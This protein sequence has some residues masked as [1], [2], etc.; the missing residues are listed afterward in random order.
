MEQIRAFIAVELPETVKEG[1]KRIQD[2]LRSTNPY[3]ARWVEPRGIHLTLKFLGN[4]D[5]NKIEAI[6]SSIKVVAQSVAPF[7]LEINGLGAF[8]NMRRVQVVWIGIKG[9]LERLQALQSSIES[10]LI[11]LGFAAENRT[12]QPHLTLARL[13]DT[14]TF[15]ER[16][17]L[18][19]ILGKTNIDSNLVIDVS[20]F[21]LIRSELTRAGA[22]YTPLCSVELTPSCQ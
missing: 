8:P 2:K 14:A 11:P 17:Y 15:Q 1:I 20:S 21:S 16:Q 6:T 5:I 18:G 10:S 19:E 7:K 13:R 12:F 4:V 3:C 22:V 9:D